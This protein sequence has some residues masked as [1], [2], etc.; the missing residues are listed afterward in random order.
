MNREHDGAAD[1]RRG[2]FLATAGLIVVTLGVCCF[3]SKE[4]SEASRETTPLPPA[5]S[6]ILDQIPPNSCRVRATIIAIDATLAD[7]S[8]TDPCARFP[9][10]ASVGIDSVLGYGSSFPR[11][12]ASGDTISVRFQ[13]T[14]APSRSAI[15][16]MRPEL[17]GLHAGSRF[18]A[19]VDG[20]GAAMKRATGGFTVRTYAVRD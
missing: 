7:A 3:P 11:A 13:Y 9:C 20:G 19:D 4:R 1:S 18:I 16:D 10:T 14:L 2:V 6:P 8:P 17:P 15:P 12:L 5:L